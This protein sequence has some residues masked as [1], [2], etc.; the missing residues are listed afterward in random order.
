MVCSELMLLG[1]ISL[2]LTV[3]QSK[4][5]GMCMP[6]RL[7]KFMLPCKYHAAEDGAAAAPTTCPA[8]MSMKHSSSHC[9]GIA[10]SEGG[11]CHLPLCPNQEAS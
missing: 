8:V 3:F 4:I 1:F 11:S 5:A 6:E 9:I 7:N 10:S 2:S